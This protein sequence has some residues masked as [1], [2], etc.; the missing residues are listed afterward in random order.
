M[1]TGVR[2]KRG[3]GRKVEMGDPGELKTTGEG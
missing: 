2:M 3:T 1:H